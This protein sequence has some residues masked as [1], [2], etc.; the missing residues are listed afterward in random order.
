MNIINCTPHTITV[1]SKEEKRDYPASGTIP[2]VLTLVNNAREV[3]G[4]PCIAQKLG[5][6]EGLP[7]P[8]PDTVYIVSGMVFSASERADLVAPDTGNTCIRENGQIVAVTRFIVKG[9]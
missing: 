7:D 4:I 2:R 5:D 6:V 9:Q 3:D 8:Q 1:I